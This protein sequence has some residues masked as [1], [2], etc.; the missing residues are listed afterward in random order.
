LRVWAEFSDGAESPVTSYRF[1]VGTQPLV[2]SETYKEN[3]WGGGAGVTGTFRFSGGMPGVT[4]F[5]YR[6]VR[7][8][9]GEQASAG[10]ATTDAAGAAEVPFTPPAAGSYDITV[11][12]HA[13]DGTATDVKSFWFGVSY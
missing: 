13:A 6:I 12:G 4:S 7:S 2:E 3:G 5:D 11:T 1:V 10:T 8:E 9:T